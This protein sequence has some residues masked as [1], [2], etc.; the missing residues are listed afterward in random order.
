MYRM[1]RLSLVIAICTCYTYMYSP[2][3]SRPYVLCD[4]IH[5]LDSSWSK[6]IVC[7]NEGDCPQ[8]QTFSMWTV[9]DQFVSVVALTLV[10]ITWL[11]D[12]CRNRMLRHCPTDDRII[13]DE[14]KGEWPLFLCN[15]LYSMWIRSLKQWGRFEFLL[16]KRFTKRW[17]VNIEQML[18][19]TPRRA[20]LSPR[21]KQNI[22]DSLPSDCCLFEV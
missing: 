19:K 2:T 11:A 5:F 15:F 4:Q 9:N 10:I 18:R 20:W 8:I 6:K 16:W 12:S 22:P 17:L 7:V 14:T 3:R 1:R 13:E 21:N